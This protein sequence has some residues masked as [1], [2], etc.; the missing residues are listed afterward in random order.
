MS[1]ENSSEVGDETLYQ[2]CGRFMSLAE[3]PKSKLNCTATINS[4]YDAFDN[5]KHMVD[6]L[7]RAFTKRTYE[8][9]LCT[10]LNN[11]NDLFLSWPDNGELSIKDVAP[12]SISSR[13]NHGNSKIIFVYGSSDFQCG[14]G[15]IISFF[16][17]LNDTH[18]DGFNV[19]IPP[20]TNSN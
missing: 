16:S 1:I 9:N 12:K 20:H 5:V 7:V 6:A 17:I 19:N 14:G 18:R 4:L 8:K 10:S 11:F 2:I 15:M 13:T 3:T